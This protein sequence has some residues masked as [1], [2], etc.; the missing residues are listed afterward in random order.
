M[1]TYSHISNILVCFVFKEEMEA[2]QEAQSKEEAED[3]TRSRTPKKIKSIL[4][5]VGRKLIAN[6]NTHA[7][8]LGLIWASI[9]YK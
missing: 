7:T 2:P 4:L 1:L 3:E 5:T 9:H 6:P 8:L